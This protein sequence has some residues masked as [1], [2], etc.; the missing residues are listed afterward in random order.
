MTQTHKVETNPETFRTEHGEQFTNNFNRKY[1]AWC[2]RRG[3]N[4]EE[5]S[6]RARA[7]RPS[8]KRAEVDL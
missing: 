3:I 5:E 2:R 6:F 4:P 1:E 8:K 7:G